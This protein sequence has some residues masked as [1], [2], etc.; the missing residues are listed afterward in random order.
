[1]AQFRDVEGI[2]DNII[3]NWTVGNNNVTPNLLGQHNTTTFAWDTKDNLLSLP[4]G[5]CR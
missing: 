4:R 3:H 2:L 5:V 1:M